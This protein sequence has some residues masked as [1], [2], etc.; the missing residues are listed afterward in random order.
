MEQPQEDLTTISIESEPV[1]LL[2]QEPTRITVYCEVNN[3][4]EDDN[5]EKFI[6]LKEE[7]ADL[8]TEC[9]DDVHETEPVASTSNEGITT[10]TT[11]V[12]EIT[13][14]DFE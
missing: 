11:E 5:K 7:D 12:I 4:K 13:L 3:S 8:M 6:R 14:E 10:T 9:L 1:E 2:I